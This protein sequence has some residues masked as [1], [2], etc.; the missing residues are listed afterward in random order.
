MAPTP[1]PAPPPKPP[2]VAKPRKVAATKL[3]PPP[4]VAR[5]CGWP[6]CD[7]RHSM[8]GACRRHAVRLVTM[9]AVGTDPATWPERWEERK[10]IAAANIDAGRRSRKGK[11]YAPRRQR[12]EVEA[13]RASL[14]ARLTDEPVPLR[15]LVAE[16]GAADHVITRALK[17]IG[18]RRVGSTHRAGWARP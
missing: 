6:G 8:R 16:L 1:P 5:L 10:A 13:L 11:Q 15:Q 2:K 9:E 3:P 18:A 7:N 17:A 4:K 12:P 14:R